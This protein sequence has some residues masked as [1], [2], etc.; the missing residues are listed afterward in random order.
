MWDVIHP[1]KFHKVVKHI[2]ILCKKSVDT[3]IVVYDN[4]SLALRLG[5][6][7]KKL[8]TMKKSETLIKENC[9]DDEQAADDFLQLM[10]H[11][12]NSEISQIALASMKARSLKESES[13]PF[14]EDLQALYLYNLCIQM[15]IYMKRVGYLGPRIF[16][17][18]ILKLL[19]F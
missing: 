18:K 19:I 13:L 12:W 9:D 4:P 10:K 5:H 6:I 16:Q 8:A 2:N 1:S 17:A 11:A 7:F 14:I 3:G 15:Y